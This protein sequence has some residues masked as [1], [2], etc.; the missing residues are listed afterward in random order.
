MRFAEAPQRDRLSRSL[1]TLRVE[2]GGHVGHDETWRDDVDANDLLDRLEIRHIAGSM[3]DPAAQLSDFPRY[4][5]CRDDVLTVTKADVMT[6]SSELKR[7][8]PSDSS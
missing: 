7:N 5:F 4:A 1:L 6:V 8:R 2:V 3:E